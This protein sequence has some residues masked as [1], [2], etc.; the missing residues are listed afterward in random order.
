MPQTAKPQSDTGEWTQVPPMGAVTVVKLSPLDDP[1]ASHEHFLTYE[2]GKAQGSPPL[3][4][5]VELR[6]HYQNEQ[7]LG[8]LIATWRHPNIGI[9]PQPQRQELTS[10]QASR[11]TDYGD[12]YVRFLHSARG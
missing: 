12:L 1:H 3:D 7:E 2:V 8:N 6:E 10:K 9:A 11:I 5:T 4:Q